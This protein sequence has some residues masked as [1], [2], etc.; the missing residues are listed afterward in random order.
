MLIIVMYAQQ[1]S[2]TASKKVVIFMFPLLL[3]YL[4]EIRWRM[5]DDCGDRVNEEVEIPGGGSDADG[6]NHSD[7]ADA[8]A[9]DV[10]EARN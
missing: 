4:G 10:E 8:I 2:D 5:S 6:G 7:A 3:A 9:V 1:H